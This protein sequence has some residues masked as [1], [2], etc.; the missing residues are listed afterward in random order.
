[1]A[2]DMH[3]GEWWYTYSWYSSRT[4]GIWVQ[5]WPKLK[6]NLKASGSTSNSDGARHQIPLAHA[7]LHTNGAPNVK[8][9]PTPLCNTTEISPDLLTLSVTMETVP[10]YSTQVLPRGLTAICLLRWSLIL[11]H[12]LQRTCS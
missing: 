3:R 5:I 7:F 12:V 11:S 2:T 6:S 9:L 4:R 1:M 8:H 10:T